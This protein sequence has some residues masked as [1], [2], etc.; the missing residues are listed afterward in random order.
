VAPP[1][2]LVLVANAAF[3]AYYSATAL[4][5]S[6]QTRNLMASQNTAFK[7]LAIAMVVIYML[8]LLYIVLERDRNRGLIV[9]VATVLIGMLTGDRSLAILLPFVFILRHRVAISTAQR[10]VFG[11][12]L[13]VVLY[14]WK[15]F[16]AAFL[17]SYNTAELYG[18][19]YVAPFSLSVLDGAAS[20][21][22][23]VAFLQAGDSPLWMG[24]SYLKIPILMTWPR[25]LGSFEVRTLAEQYSWHFAPGMAA[26]G[27]G[28]GFSALAEAWLNF[29]FA[30]P[31]LLGAAWGAVCKHFDSRA[32][33]IGFYM[34]AL[35]LLRI[36]R[37]D[38]A[39]LYKS[40]FLVPAVILIAWMV[41]LYIIEH[42]RARRD[43]DDGLVLAPE[44]TS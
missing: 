37:S 29:G 25:F 13:V 31:A 14:Y 8:D 44:L 5:M 40:M 22:M 16:Y 33:G 20:Y 19:G 26:Y 11:G 10:F 4:T 41:L 23:F 28:L 2:W 27:G 34:V 38:F 3:A 1:L 18:P 15:T 32:R 17:I 43:E 12:A 24:S 9:V 39:S 6:R 7:L 30:G 35:M 36:F 42:V 21:S